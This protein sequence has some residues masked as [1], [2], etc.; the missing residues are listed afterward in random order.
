MGCHIQNERKFSATR[1]VK[2]PPIYLKSLV[3]DKLIN[4]QML[5]QSAKVAKMQKKL[6]CEKGHVETDFLGI[7]GCSTYKNL[8]KDT[9]IGRGYHTSY[10][11]RPFLNGD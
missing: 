9:K 5:I 4:R 8:S 6:I 2:K 7:K 11:E 10:K 1:S 3:I